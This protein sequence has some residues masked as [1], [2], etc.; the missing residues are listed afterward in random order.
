MAAALVKQL[1]EAAKKVAED[2]QEGQ[3]DDD[4]TNSSDKEPP[5]KVPT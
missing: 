1:Q 5:D 4:I 2:P 3:E